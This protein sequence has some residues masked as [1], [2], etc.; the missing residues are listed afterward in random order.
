[1]KISSMVSAILLSFAVLLTGCN[2]SGY[3]ATND[4]LYPCLSRGYDYQTCSSAYSVYGVHDSHWMD[5]VGPFV[6]GMGAMALL[7]NLSSMPR[8]Q[9]PQYQSYY[10]DYQANPNQYV[11]RSAPQLKP[12]TYYKQNPVKLAPAADGKPQALFQPNT[13]A[14]PRPAAPGLANGVP[15]MTTQKPAIQP[16]GNNPFAVRPPTAA[17]SVSAPVS[18][19]N[20]FSVNRAAPSSPRSNP[21]S[22]SRPSSSKR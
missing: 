17:P 2:S 9:T 12:E 6:A 21:F 16:G 11:Q 1:M 20:P 14:A 18:K 5:G 7:N 3:N 22:V 8:Y 4:P 13:V 15:P 10:R 19:P